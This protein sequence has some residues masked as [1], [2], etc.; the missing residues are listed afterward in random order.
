MG[1]NIDFN[2]MFGVS[3]QI[4][5]PRC[6]NMTDTC[7]E[8]YDIDCGE[9]NPEIGVWVLV[10]CCNVCEHDIEYKFK[11]ELNPEIREI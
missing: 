10:T 2:E 5:C 7:F 6:N 9:C 1:R 8:E 4:K 3:L 11:V